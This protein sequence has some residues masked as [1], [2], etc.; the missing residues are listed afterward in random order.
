LRYGIPDF[1]LD[2]GVID[3]RLEQLRAEGI[4]F[5]TGVTVGTDISANYLHKMFDCICLTMGA[6]QPRDLAVQ[7][8]GYDNILFAIDYLSQQNKKCGGE[9]INGDVITAKDKHIVVIGGGDTGSDC[10]GTARRQGAKEIWQ[11]EILPQPPDDRPPDTPWPFWPRIMRTS[12]SHEEGC[13]RRWSVMTRKFTG[14]DTRVEGLEG[15]KVEWTK[16]DGQWKLREISGSEFTLKADLVLL[17]LGFVHVLHEG[18][19]KE[20]GLELDKSGNVKVENFQTSQPWV[21]AAGDTVSGASLVVRAIDAGRKAAE[22]IDNRLKN[23]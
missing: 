20:L 10:V 12:T 9:K 13:E 1:K 18:L 5:Q 8:R 21:F 22:A 2:K 11:L 17:A 3:R 16:K 6:N 23:S 4:D 19:V 15:V 7:G 14:A